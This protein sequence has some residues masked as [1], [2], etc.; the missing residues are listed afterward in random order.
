M[1]FLRN[2]QKHCQSHHAMQ[3]YTQSGCHQSRLLR[4]HSHSLRYKPFSTS[5][6]YFTFSFFPIELSFG[7]LYRLLLS[8]LLLWI[9]LNHR[10]KPTI[11]KLF[12]ILY[13]ICKYVTFFFFFINCKYMACSRRCIVVTIDGA[14]YDVDVDVVYQWF[15]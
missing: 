14:S 9:S 4:H 13:I 1:E 15:Q 12:F 11:S 7:I 8:L 2:T 10:S 5:T 3:N 6:D